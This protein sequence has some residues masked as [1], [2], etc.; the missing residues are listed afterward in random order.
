[1]RSIKRSFPSSFLLLFKANKHLMWG[2]FQSFSFY[3]FF[4]KSLYLDNLYPFALFIFIIMVSNNIKA[5]FI[6][7]LEKIVISQATSRISS[8]ERTWERLLL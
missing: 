1:M 3:I 6:T 4:L 8:P 2:F 5:N 7:F